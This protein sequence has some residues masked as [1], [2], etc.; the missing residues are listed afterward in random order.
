MAKPGEDDD[1]DR[2]GPGDNGDGSTQDNGAKKPAVGGG[3]KKPAEG[4]DGKKPAHGPKEL[5]NP[6]AFVSSALEAAKGGPS[7]MFV[8]AGA[9]I[10]GLAALMVPTLLA[11]NRPDY[12]SGI[13]L[14]ATGAVALFTWLAA[15]N[16]G[17]FLVQ[18]EWRLIQQP[19]H[20]DKL[21]LLAQRLEAVRGVAAEAFVK[22]KHEIG[23]KDK[24][25]ANI[26]LADYRRAPEGVGCELRM[27]A[28]FRLKMKNPAEWELA[29]QPGEGATGEA[30]SSAQP[31]LTNNRMYGVPTAL[32]DVFDK[33]IDAGLKAIVSLPILDNKNSNVTAVVNIDLCDDTADATKY[34]VDYDDL[35]A[36]YEAIKKANGFATVGG[37]LNKLDKAWLT[38]GLRNG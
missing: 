1:D 22:R 36:V 6:L 8:W 7:Q 29:F 38:I 24:V 10:L 16:P 32:H 31:V 34:S 25:R 20:G 9:S 30:F 12:A 5:Q 35:N 3:G 11:N 27:P 4:G 33:K 19:L 37:E 21:D 14:V 23:D 13:F 2:P 26:F 18:R 15:K 28:L 17:N